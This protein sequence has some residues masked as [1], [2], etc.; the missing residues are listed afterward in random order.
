MPR[1]MASAGAALVL[2]TLHA[3]HAGRKLIFWHWIN[4]CCKCETHQSIYACICLPTLHTADCQKLKQ[5][6]DE[7]HATCI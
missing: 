7:K 1:R 5:V 6:I 2:T 3:T 4:S